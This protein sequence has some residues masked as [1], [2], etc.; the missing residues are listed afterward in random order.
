MSLTQEKLPH[1]VTYQ[2][3]KK[4]KLDKE[5]LIVQVAFKGTA[6]QKDGLRDA[7]CNAVSFKC[8]DE[9]ECKKQ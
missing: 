9:E 4:I 5:K 2:N 6:D 8:C 3:P 7:Q 1:L